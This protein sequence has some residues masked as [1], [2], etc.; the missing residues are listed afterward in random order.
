MTN[1]DEELRAK[2]T[3]SGALASAGGVAAGKKGVAVG[4]DVLG[5]IIK[6]VNVIAIFGGIEGPGQD[7]LHDIGRQIKESLSAGQAEPDEIISLIRLPVEQQ[8]G[9]KTAADLVDYLDLAGETFGPLVEKYDN[10]NDTQTFPFGDFLQDMIAL[11]GTSNL[12]AKTCFDRF[13]DE[14]QAISCQHLEVMFAKPLKYQTLRLLAVERIPQSD[15]GRLLFHDAPLFLYR[16]VDAWSEQE[17]C[18]GHFYQRGDIQVV[19][20]LQFRGEELLAC[21]RWQR[22]DYLFFGSLASGL[23]ADFVL[24]A[25]RLRI[26]QSTARRILTLLS[27]FKSQGRDRNS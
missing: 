27:G 18:L 17:L 9:E 14:K 12:L 4:G 21:R 20:P 13:G 19:C 6:A 2:V 7:I 25:H 10:Y 8:L 26:E 23:L 15:L 16:R 11:M 1:P 3:G 22:I 24:Y 5:S